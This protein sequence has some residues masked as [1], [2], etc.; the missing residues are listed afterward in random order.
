MPARTPPLARLAPLH[1]LACITLLAACGDEPAAPI[2][3]NAAELRG[4]PLAPR[5]EAPIVSATALL[6]APDGAASSN[7]AAA[8]NAA[9]GAALPILDGPGGDAPIAVAAP[10]ELAPPPESDAAGVE[11]AAKTGGE[12]KI[13]KDY[14]PVLFKDIS[15]WTYSQPTAKE[16][17]QDPDAVAKS[18]KERIPADIWALD[19]KK[20]AL[21]GFMSPIDFDKTGVKS[22]SLIHNAIGCCFG[23]FPKMNEWVYVEMAGDKK[24]DF[25]SVEPATIYGTFSVGEEIRDGYV[26]S[27]FRLKAD[28]V[29]GT[30]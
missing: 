10:R 5:V 15:T 4:E 9:P 25:F 27:L 6:A 29:F 11:A 2:A 23:M 13:A 30:F 22:F 21:E 24:C 16:L 3:A 12:G 26:V 28:H 14:K 18:A 19:G 7:D 8:P 17:E 20:I 1:A